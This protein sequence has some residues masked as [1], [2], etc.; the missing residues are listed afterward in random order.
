M[1]LNIFAVLLLTACGGSKYDNAINE[2][3]YEEMAH[4]PDDGDGDR[5]GHYKKTPDYKDVKGKEIKLRSRLYV[6][7]FFVVGLTS[8]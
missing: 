2:V 7:S 4:M 5:L 3:I 8:Y 6:C 1:F